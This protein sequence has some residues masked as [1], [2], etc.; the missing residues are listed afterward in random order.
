[1]RKVIVAAMAASL[2]STS[3]IAGVTATPEAQDGIS[4]ITYLKG[5]PTV[6]IARPSGDIRI[7]PLPDDHGRLSFGVAVFNK[8]ATAA[9]FGIE[10]ISVTV[11]DI[12]V[13][14]LSREKLQ[15]MA[16]N[17]AGWAQF[18]VALA[19]GLQAASAQ[20]SYH[21]TTYTPYGVY[22]TRATVYDPV[23]ANMA[24]DR[25]AAESAMIQDR[26]NATLAN[27]GDE[28]VQT[29]TVEPNTPYGGRIV[30]DKFKTKAFPDKITLMIHWNG[31]DYP[32][33]FDL[34]KS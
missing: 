21:S 12:S 34:N 13:A 3:L 17:R 8:G 16:A 26:L 27:L 31:D 32:F 1:M 4:T 19:G 24:L 11:D 29:T 23:A 7:T 9:N 28:I 14:I 10:T 33:T 5:T 6:D 30:L 22:H 25:S 18:A 2:I 20:S 15:K